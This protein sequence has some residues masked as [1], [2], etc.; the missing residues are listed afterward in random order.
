M[1]NTHLIEQL[2]KADGSD[3][4]MP[5]PGIWISAD[6]MA[7]EFYFTILADLGQKD[8][9]PNILDNVELLAH[10]TK[11]YEPIRNRT[12]IWDNN[13]RVN[14]T[15]GLAHHAFTSKARSRNNLGI[16]HSVISTTFLC[17][18]PRLKRRP[19]LIVSVIINT[20][21]ILSA[22]WR[23]YQSLIDTILSKNDPEMMNCVGSMATTSR[24]VEHEAMYPSVQSSQNSSGTPSGNKALYSSVRQEDSL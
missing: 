11:G 18:I 8:S 15:E 19:T 12:P 16:E 14:T 10:S 3:Q 2:S 13:L 20:I 6:N 17:Q 24:E 9:G 4:L 5:L 21:V 22:L 1:N 23:L 7:K